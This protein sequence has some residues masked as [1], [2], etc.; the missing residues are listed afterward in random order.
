MGHQIDE[1]AGTK[2]PLYVANRA[3][4]NFL[5]N[6][7]MA[8]IIALVAELNGADRY[9]IPAYPTH[10]PLDRYTNLLERVIVNFVP[11]YLPV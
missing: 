2:D 5:E 8:L 9:D 11:N 1:K 4:V 10:H 6:V 7:P 3:L